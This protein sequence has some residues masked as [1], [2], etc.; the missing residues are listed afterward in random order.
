MEITY[1]YGNVLFIHW[2]SIE[3][4]GISHKWQI[5]QKKK[6]YLIGLTINNRLVFSKKIMSLFSLDRSCS[7]NFSKQQK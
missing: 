5:S 1:I 7:S 2:E 3:M 4:V 6:S